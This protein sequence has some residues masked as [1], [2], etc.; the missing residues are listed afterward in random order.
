LDLPFAT[1]PIPLLLDPTGSA[2][3]WL[4]EF[5]KTQQN[6]KFEVLNQH[7]DRFTYNLE[8]GVRFGKIVLIDD[9][10]NQFTSS[11][12]SLISMKIFSRFNKKMM[13]IGNKLIDLHEDFRLILITSTEIKRLNGEINANVTIVPFTLTASGLKGEESFHQIQRNLQISS[14]QINFCQS[15]YP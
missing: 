15:G 4:T 3:K 13:Q 6:R 2:L 8:L 5:L 10:S 11:L 14:F 12:L 7:D 1:G 9:V